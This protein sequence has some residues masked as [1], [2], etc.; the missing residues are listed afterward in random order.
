[1]SIIKHL[2]QVRTPNRPKKKTRKKNHKKEEKKFTAF[3]Q[4]DRERS[5]GEGGRHS[6]NTNDDTM[7][8]AGESVDKRTIVFSGKRGQCE[9]GQSLY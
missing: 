4:E 3:K 8:T 1:M 5:G 2:W 9:R 7:N 6:G